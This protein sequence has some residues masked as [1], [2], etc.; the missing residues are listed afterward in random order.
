MSKLLKY[1][2]PY[3]LALIVIFGLVYVQVWTDLQ[4][5]DYMA[6]IINQGIVGED[7]GIIWSTGG[8]MLLVSMLGAACTVAYGYLAVKVATGFSK[9]LREAVFT[10]VESFSL[11]EFDKFSTASLITRSTNDIQQIQMVLIM[12][13]RMVLSA[14]ILGVG[15]II[16]AYNKAPNMSW[17]IGLAV[18][19][20]FAMVIVV[21]KVAVPKFKILQKLVDKLNL[22]TRE[23]LTG[24]RVI[25]AFNAEPY[26]ETKFE[27]ANKDLTDINLFV[28]RVMVVMQPAMMLIFNVVSI[29]IVWVG[30]HFI[31][32]GDLQVGDMIAFMQYAMQVILAFLMMTII[33]ILVPRGSVSAIRVAEVIGTDPII[34]DPEHPK[35]YSPDVKGLVEFKNVTFSYPGAD[36]P[37]L[38]DISFTAKS[39]QTTAFIGSTGSGKSTLINLIPRFYDVT[40][41][42]VLIDG[43]DVR[44]VSKVDLCDKIGYVPQKGI[45]FSGSVNSNIK[46][47]VD[48]A[49][50]DLITAA[51]KTSQAYDFVME[52]EDGFETTI[53]QGGLNV[54]GGQK[55][56]LAIARAIIKK[57]EIYIFDDSFSA[58]D[59]ATDAALREALGAETKNAAVLIVA[60][61]I[62]TI[63]NADQI[64]VLDEGRIVGA[65]RH[66]ELLKTNPVYQEIASSQLSEE[67]LSGRRDTG[68]Q[69]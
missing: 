41:G 60:Q 28:N 1:L 49:S 10:K 37:V 13:M 3:T 64:I 14:P 6:K 27:K 25:R 58:L 33:F 57:P 38:K 5:P 11:R 24:L 35:K 67:E 50:E 30:A 15:A 55:Q 2:K 43:L 69:S 8:L 22:V 19:V 59:M 7:S 4:L 54:S 48:D 62:G 52:L 65:G 36:S 12:L 42:S 47:G 56:R 44:E 31:G 53:A 9:N 66:A 20:L 68:K 61:R 23:N 40:E 63:M 45:L 39:G 32:S 46:F 21:F 26:E 34:K 18:A 17:I 16:K 51:A 29:S